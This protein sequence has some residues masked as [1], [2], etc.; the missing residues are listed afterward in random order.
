MERG[1]RF[2]QRCAPLFVVL[3]TLLL[4][5]PTTAAQ[6]P[7]PAGGSPDSVAAPQGVDDNYLEV[8]VEWVN[9]YPYCCRNTS[10]GQ[11][12]GNNVCDLS[13]C[14]DD[15][16]GLRN[17]LGS[18]GWIKGFDY[19][20]GMAWE[21]DFKG[22]TKPGGG[23]EYMYVDT[24]DLAYFSGHGGSGGFIFGEGGRNHDD[25][26]LTYSDCRLEWGDKD[27][28]WIAI[29]SCQALADAHR[30]D[31]SWC[32]DGLHLIMGFVTN[33]ADSAHGAWLG[34]LICHGF[35]MTQ[36]WFTASDISQP[37]GR[38]VRV[39]AEEYH[40]FF[41]RPSD[42][43]ASDAL[44]YSTYWYWDHHTASAPP[45]QVD[46]SLLQG[47]MPVFLTPRLSLD[48]AN[49]QWEQLGTAFGVEDTP[50]SESHSAAEGEL[51]ISGDNQLQMDPSS[52]LY[53]Y[54]ELDSLWAPPPTTTPASEATPQ[55]TLQ[56]A[57][58]IADQFLTSNDLMPA[59]AVFDQVEADTL[60]GVELST[61]QYATETTLQS[62][63]TALQVVYSRILTY[64]L[65]SLT[66]AAQETV[67]FSVMGPGAK[68]KV[69]V[70]PQAVPGR[71][72]AEPA[73]DAVI[74][75]TGGWRPLAQTGTSRRA[76]QDTVPILDYSQIEEL[77]ESL[78]PSVAL[79]YIPLLFE[80]RQVLSHTVAYYEHPMGT[81]QDQLIPVYALEVEYTLESQ[82]VTTDTVYIPANPEYMAPL[83]LIS[84]TMEI[85]ESIGTGQEIVFEAVDATQNLSD[86]GYDASLNFP[87][88][89]GDP[90][91]YLYTWYRDSVS[92]A[93]RIG[94]GRVFTY[95]VG[96]A[97]ETHPG[98]APV[99][100]S[101]I[102]EVT[103]SYSPRPPSA[104]Y[105]QVQLAVV[106]PIYLPLVLRNN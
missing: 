93:T 25:A 87:L 101:I 15:A 8:G 106:P 43:N 19:G 52:G 41:D 96:L 72:I 84:P 48:A 21:E 92:D 66:N 97:G 89:T 40:H 38:I 83:A 64:T 39:L 58:E 50:R 80:S 79:S 28:E 33:M 7:L 70:D 68:L 9:D 10:S 69:F 12:C 95:T 85:P 27:M 75:G 4:S 67:E 59:D 16:E 56:D 105:D 54:T 23:T 82:E 90:D 32:M 103:D 76:I 99:S 94:T 91:S 102:L 34:W 6:G 55:L 26:Y 73:Q 24:V 30:E 63:D 47:E 13:L 81:G 18:C 20:N 45:R 22:Q 100:Q 46:I 3:L 57:K 65:P 37:S 11:V 42:H 77:F 17:Q 78:E 29:S 74:G 14:D 98:M 51:W 36:A 5:L 44:D 60:T 35:N 104:N 53:T 62:E 1:N 88:G 49:A 86:V 61:S 31:W 71:S 2:R